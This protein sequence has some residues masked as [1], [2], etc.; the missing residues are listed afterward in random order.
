[1]LHNTDKNKQLN[2]NVSIALL[3]FILGTFVISPL[4]KDIAAD[5][6]GMHNYLLFSFVIGC[7]CLVMLPLLA[8]SLP[9]FRQ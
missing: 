3:G 9:S 8:D 2:K 4:V 7:V 6:L 5:L 1:M